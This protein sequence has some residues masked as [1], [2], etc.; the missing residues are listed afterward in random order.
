M[1]FLFSL[2]VSFAQA[3]T[4]ADY[5]QKNA[6]VVSGVS[7]PTSALSELSASKLVL[8]GDF[9]GTT[10]IPMAVFDILKSL[11]AG[12]KIDF[13]I[14]F[15]EEIQPAVD[16]FLANGDSKVLSNTTFF[17]DISRHS[18]KA[19]VAMVELLSKLRSLKNVKVFCFD[20]NSGSILDSKERETALA[21][22]ILKKM[23]KLN[24]NKTV[25]FTGNV[26]SRI[27]RGVPWD[28]AYPAM[29]SE[30]LRL[31]NSLDQIGTP[32]SVLF[33]L[34]KGSAFNCLVLN[35]REECATHDFDYSMSV[36][37]STVV[38]N[39]F[40]VEP[41]ITDGHNFSFILQTVGASAPFSSL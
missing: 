41:Q 22:T 27:V 25:I 11:S 5:I 38:G 24:R 10:E 1:I 29:G 40:L 31:S 16:A 26:H 36:Y 13:G 35:G 7:L 21:K 32:A 4:S 30:I 2:F 28:P 17:Q 15:P 19:S 8:L 6:Q 33:R 12:E 14:E 37:F 39:Y 3:Q 20:V 9:H 34:G 23:R 18:G